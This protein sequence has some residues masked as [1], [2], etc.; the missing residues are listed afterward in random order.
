MELVAL[1][2]YA[3]V[4]KDA[5]ADFLAKKYGFFHVKF[6]DQIK[7][8]VGGL[9]G[10]PARRFEDRDWKES[11]IDWLGRSPRELLQTLGTEWG[12]EMVHPDIWVRATIRRINYMTRVVISDC[13]FDNE[14]AAVKAAGGKVIQIIRPGYDPVNSHKSETAL[15]PHLVDR[16]L[17]NDGTLDGLLWHLVWKL[18][19]LGFQMS[20]R[21]EE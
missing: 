3:G 15:S 5:C 6:A 17:V 7:A 21:E 16:V 20:P 13:R 18:D 10:V 9:L 19:G 1:A 8:M 4:G 14:A 2:G 12:R 11:P